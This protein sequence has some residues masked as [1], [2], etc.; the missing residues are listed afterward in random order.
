MDPAGTKP[1]LEVNPEIPGSPKSRAQPGNGRSFRL[2]KR[3]ACTVAASVV[4]VL[5]VVAVVA[6]AVLVL[7]AQPQFMAWCPDGWIGYQG[8]CYYFSETE[9]NWNN[10]QRRCSALGASLARIDS[11]QD[12]AFMMQYKG[13]SE[14]WIGLWREQMGQPWKWVNGSDLNIPLLIRGGGNCVYLNNNSINSSSCRAGRNWVCSKPNAYTV[15][16]VL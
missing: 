15:R 14:H 9:E 1:W 10:S 3:A 12:L 11:E 8:K 4:L 5:L 6:L 2:R 7:K 13:V 16:K